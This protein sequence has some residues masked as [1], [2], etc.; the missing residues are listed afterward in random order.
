MREKVEKLTE[1]QES[2]KKAQGLVA[3]NAKKLEDSRVAFLAC[4]QEAKV[5][6]DTI[7]VKAGSEPGVE[8]PE[9]DPVAFLSWLKAEVSQLVPLL[10]I[11]LD[12]GAYGVTLAVARSF[13][14][15]G[16]DHHKKL[17][18]VNHNFPII[19]DVR[20]ATKDRAYKN[21]CEHFL[22]KFG[23]KA[24]LCSSFWRGCG[25]RIGGG[26]GGFML[27][28]FYCNLIWLLSYVFMFC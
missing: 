26:K 14:A 4:M 21:V 9:V 10:D 6:L 13:Q 15:A 2:Y 20:G 24:S 8:L 3:S 22:K 17:G 11:V 1:V 25:R 16:C 23:C 28:Y 27:L 12:F 18:Q 19:E 5:A 7:F